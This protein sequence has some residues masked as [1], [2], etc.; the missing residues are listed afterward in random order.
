MWLRLLYNQYY[1]NILIIDVISKVEMAKKQSSVKTS[2]KAVSARVSYNDKRKVKK[3]NQSTKSNKKSPQVR[4]KTFKE[5]SDSAIEFINY[6]LHDRFNFEYT[7]KT[8]KKLVS[9]GP[10]LATLFVV[11]ISPQLLILAKN[12]NL[13]TISGFFN[14]IFFNQKSWVILVLILLNILFLVDGL[15]DL[16]AKKARGWTR[17]YITTLTTLTYVFYQ[18]IVNISEP[19]PAILALLGSIL[20]VYTILD[21]RNFY[22]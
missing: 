6:N 21:I 3:L 1:D 10:W 9:Y 15:N 16:F 14:Q 4:V 7:V 17:V 2:R 19:A 20:V 18:L 11:V 12:G 22:K 5:I 13:I 8:K